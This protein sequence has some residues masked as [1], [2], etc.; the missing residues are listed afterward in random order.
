MSEISSNVHVINRIRHSKFRFAVW[1]IRSYELKKF[2]PMALLLFFVLLNQNLIRSVKDS[3][4]VT[5][6]GPQVIS[7]IK[8]WVEMPA[9]VLF[10]I[11]YTKLC[12]IMTTEQV[13]RIIVSIFL[14]FFTAFAFVIF[15]N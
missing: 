9:G 4:V 5:M 10:V 15:P 12:N 14:I 1:P 3:F 7:F 6:I 8:L 11:L 13:F 2:M